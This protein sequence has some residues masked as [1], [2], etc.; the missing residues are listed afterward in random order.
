ME[1]ILFGR[2]GLKV[3]R[4]CFGTIP[5]GGKGWRK[6]PYLEP[7]EAGK[8]L[9]RAFELGINFWD[10]A[11]GYRSHPHVREGLKY[12]PREEIILST[13]TTQKT[14]EGAKES[15]KKT[16]QEIGT[17]YID[18]YY[19]HYVKSPE[20]LENRK[21]AIQAFKEAIDEGYVR[22]IGVSTHWNEVVEKL[23]EFLEIEVVMVK[24]NK[25]GRMDSPLQAMLK[26]VEKA[27]INGK[28]IVCMKI[29]A[30]GDLSIREGLEYALNL[31]FIHSVCLGMRT[32][33]EV[34][35]DVKIYQRIVQES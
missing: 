34:E 22:H 11:E 5:F 20:D 13:K 12:V 19:L 32:I 30:Y 31:P 18:I 4:I 26:A 28:G 25:I 24:L 7:T 2:T 27:Y 16:L 15:L 29:A 6:D 35:E 8:V 33:Q 9:K 23:L 21:G 14:Y 3:S 1:K 10:T 17:D